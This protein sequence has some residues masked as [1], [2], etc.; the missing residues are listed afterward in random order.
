MASA[1]D[2]NGDGFADVIV[3]ATDCD[4]DGLE[5][6]GA[7][8][9]FLGSASGIPDGDPS[10]AAVTVASNEEFSY[11]GQSVATAGDV[12][13]DGRAEVIV[14]GPFNDAGQTGEGI[15]R[16]VPEP[17]AWLAVASGVRAA[18]RRSRGGGA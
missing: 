13:G 16:V 9:V 14:G 7:A 15:A 11:F 10:T 4:V 1:G 8:F 6:V 3:G 18:R 12:N 17:T 5:D 2:W